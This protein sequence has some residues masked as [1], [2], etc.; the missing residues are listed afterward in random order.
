MN[1]ST[2][3]NLIIQKFFGRYELLIGFQTLGTKQTTVLKGD[4][5]WLLATH[6]QIILRYF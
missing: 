4:Y 5:S 3:K 6:A 1:I 2:F